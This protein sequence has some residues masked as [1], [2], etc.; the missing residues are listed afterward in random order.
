M[1]M[2]TDLKWNTCVDL[3]LHSG[4][5]SVKNIFQ[6]TFVLQSIRS[7]SVLGGYSV[8]CLVNCILGLYIFK[9]GS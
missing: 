9:R 6:K 4:L 8:F 7:S 5:Q 3:F 2:S 1:K